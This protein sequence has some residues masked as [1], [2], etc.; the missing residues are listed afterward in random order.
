MGVPSS[1]PPPPVDVRRDAQE[2]GLTFGGRLPAAT[3]A[4]DDSSPSRVAASDKVVEPSFE[5][6]RP[7]EAAERFFLRD[8]LGE[9]KSDDKLR[10][11]GGVTSPTLALP[12]CL[13][14]GGGRCCSNAVSPA[15]TF[16][17]VPSGPF[18]TACTRNSHL[19]RARARHA[20]S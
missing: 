14:G 11:D 13:C 17:M 8:L 6:D 7:R 12:F 2:R 19:S 20:R 3:E 4:D 1:P 18:S 10:G 15:S 5:R 9:S 16:A